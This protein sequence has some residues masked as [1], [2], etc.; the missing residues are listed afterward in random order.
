MCLFQCG[1]RV[2][3]RVTVKEVL[4]LVDGGQHGNHTQQATMHRDSD[5]TC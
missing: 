3:G 2:R 4:M 5:Q 1:G